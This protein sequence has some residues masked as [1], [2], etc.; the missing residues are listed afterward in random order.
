[1]LPRAAASMKQCKTGACRSA[2]VVGTDVDHEICST[3]LKA[4]MCKAVPS[5]CFPYK[6]Q[7]VAV[8]TAAQLAQTLSMKGPACY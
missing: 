5:F 2:Q 1:V 7:H 4:G 8:L 6:P 3:R